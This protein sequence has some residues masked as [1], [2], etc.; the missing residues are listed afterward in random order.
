[1]GNIVGNLFGGGV[2]KKDASKAANIQADYQ[3]EALDYLKQTEALPQQYREAALGAKLARW[4]WRVGQKLS[5][6]STIT[7]QAPQCITL[8][9]AD[10]RRARNL[11]SG[12]KQLLAA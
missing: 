9:W 11:F 12:T 8:S 2:G 5:R 4:D 3:R 6:R 1:M 7:C 10:S